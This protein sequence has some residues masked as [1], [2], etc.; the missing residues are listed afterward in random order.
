MINV[1]YSSG[2]CVGCLLRHVVTNLQHPVRVPTG[3]LA[4][5]RRA[6]A[7]RRERIE[8]TVN[9]DGC[10]SFPGQESRL[11]DGV[12]GVACFVD[13]LVFLVEVI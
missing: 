3:E 1:D 5:V 8:F 6:V 12:D 11:R 9:G 2:E 4:A 7:G 13:T 10:G